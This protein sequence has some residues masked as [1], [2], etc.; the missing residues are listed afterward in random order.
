MDFCIYP[1]VV[2]RSFE[3][4]VFS[5]KQQSRSQHVRNSISKLPGL[6]QYRH[7]LWRAQHHLRHRLLR[8]LRWKHLRLN[9]MSDDIWRFRKSILY[10]LCCYE[11]WRSFRSVLAS[12]LLASISDIFDF[13]KYLLI[14]I[15]G[16]I[17][18][19]RDGS[20]LD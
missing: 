2:L 6:M 8:E 10:R 4:P 12:Q 3:H 16:G 5:H 9:N 18:V 7:T 17:F 11:P 14:F 15:F 13:N 20:S 19:L 1:S